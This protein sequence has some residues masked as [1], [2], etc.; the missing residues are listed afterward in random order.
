V[1]WRRN[2]CWGGEGVG[3]WQEKD[4]LVEVKESSQGE[5]KEERKK[6]LQQANRATRQHQPAIDL[7]HRLMEPGN[8]EG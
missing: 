7:T 1:T 3:T 6:R 8:G 4:L 5:R 2:E